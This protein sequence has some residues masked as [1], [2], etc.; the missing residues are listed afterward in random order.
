MAT[1]KKSSTVKKT[2]KTASKKQVPM[3]SF[4]LTK[5]TPP[6]LAFNITH[7]TFYWSVLCVLILALGVWVVSLNVQVQSLYDQIDLIN[8]K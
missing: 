4:V 5:D 6:F 3:R 8:T 1:A 7:Q 2:H